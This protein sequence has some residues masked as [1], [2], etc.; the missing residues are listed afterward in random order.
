MVRLPWNGMST[1]ATSA[2]AETARAM[3]GRADCPTGL[4]ERF[5]RAGVPPCYESATLLSA[6]RD[7]HTAGPCA[8]QTDPAPGAKDQVVHHLDSEQ[9]ASRHGLLRRPPVVG[10]R[11]RDSGGVVV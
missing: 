7:S 3:T 2:S 5:R 11:R 9:A 1:M 8:L 4:W 6:S 10:G